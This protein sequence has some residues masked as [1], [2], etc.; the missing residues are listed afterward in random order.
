MAFG[1]N[2]PIRRTT[3]IFPTVSGSSMLVHYRGSS[4]DVVA[5]DVEV[6]P[7]QVQAFIEMKLDA[8]KGMSL[9]SV[10]NYLFTIGLHEWRLAGSFEVTAD[11]N[12]NAHIIVH[13]EGLVAG[14]TVRVSGVFTA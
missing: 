13:S 8:V 7:A 14:D 12:G 3:K 1:A 10:S 9:S 2:A 5:L 11:I 4:F 6:A